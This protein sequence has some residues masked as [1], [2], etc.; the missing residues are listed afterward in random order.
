ME[1]IE[2]IESNI[3]QAYE[4]IDKLFRNNKG[5]YDENS[6]QEWQEEKIKSSDFFSHIKDSEVRDTFSYYLILI[7]EFKQEAQSK[8]LQCMSQFNYS[9]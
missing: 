1:D 3:T 8:R 6:Y 9:C 4:M 2:T 5:K 7:N